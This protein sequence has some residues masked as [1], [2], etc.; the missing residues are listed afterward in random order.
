MIPPAHLDVHWTGAMLAALRT[1]SAQTQPAA[2]SSIVSELLL[3][4]LGERAALLF[5]DAEAALLWSA[6]E[7][8]REGPA[9]LGLAGHAARTGESVTVARAALDP[10]YHPALDD[11]EGDGRQRLSVQPVCRQGAEIHAVLVVA[12]SAAGPEPSPL[13]QARLSALAHHLAPLLEQLALAASLEPPLEGAEAEPDAGSPF[14]PEALEAYARARWQGE[15]VQLD[16]PWLSWCYRALV[17]LSLCALLY[18]GLV[19]IGDY[20]TGPALV[21]LGEGEVT[22][23]RSG[24][25]VEVLVTPGEQVEEGRPLVRLYDDADVAL[26]QRLEL[27]FTSQLRNLLR[28]PA[29]QTAQQAVTAL[30]AQKTEAWARR[31]EQVVRAPR[32]ARVRDVR[33]RRGQVVQP[34]DVLLSLEGSGPGHVLALL[35]GDERPRIQPGMPLVFEIDG[36]WDA[37][38]TLQIEQVSEDVLGPA[39]AARLLGP[40]ATALSLEGPVT[41]VRARLS[42][43]SFASGD[44]RY[45]LHDGMAGQAWVRVRAIPLWRELWP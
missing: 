41:L 5:H 32:A 9:A 7:P 8:E 34:G 23:V 6:T 12:R 27:E 42:Q 10:R 17:A 39:E 1:A 25:V 26:V 14:R 45:R 40:G 37:A 21:R 22:A 38:P 28:D 18:G 3:D 13:D 44:A 33:T 4:W 19:Q 43:D 24:S 29:D 30:R 20:A 31:Q 11:P 35:P 15:P 16:P 36:F 2:V